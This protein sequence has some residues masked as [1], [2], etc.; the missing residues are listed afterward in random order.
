MRNATVALSDAQVERAAFYAAIVEGYVGDESGSTV[1]FDYT[2]RETGVKSSR[3]AQVLEVVGTPGTSTHAWKGMTDK[4]PRTFN[5][6][7]MG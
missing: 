5:F 4:G 7:L 1:I 6:Y 2:N 3:E